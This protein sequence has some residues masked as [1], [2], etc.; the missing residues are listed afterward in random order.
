MLKRFLGD[1]SGNYAILLGIT[2]LPLLLA[3]GFGVDYVRYV[4]AKQHL[5]DLTDAASLAVAGSPERDDAKLRALA[6]K[7][8]GG[9]ASDSRIENVTVASLDI[10]NDQVD[11]AL[12][13]DIP[14]YFM[15]LANIHRLYV[16]TSALAMRAVTGSVEV[17]LVLDNTASMLNND[18][19]GT[20][21]T[22][23][24]ALVTE[25]FKS[26]DANV[27]IGLVPYAE[28][29]NIGMANRNA[30]YL[31]VPADYDNVVKGTCKTITEENG[32]CLA[33]SPTTTCTGYRDGVPYTYSCGGGCTKYEKI[34][35]TPYEVC[36]ADK[37]QT[38]KWYGCI[39]SRVDTGTRKLV[40]DD[41]S[42]SILYPGRMN[43]NKVQECV[44]EILPLTS[45]ESTVQSAIT[46]MIT[47]RSGYEPNTY[48]PAGMI[49][50]VN[51]LSPSAPMTEG[52]DYDE[53]NTN[54]R[55]VIVL[56][57]DGLN[58]RSVQKTGANAGFYNTANTPEQQAP[59]N[60]D[61]ETVCTYAKSK[62][63]EVFSIAFMVDDGA[64][65]TMLQNCATDANHYYDASD[66]SKLLAAF[67]G[68]AQSLSQVRLAR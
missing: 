43:A 4:S 24:A 21:K 17:A 45:S 41:Q 9:N 54:P 11:L 38:Y 52:A 40:L 62:K 56:M 31:S 27:R 7:M 10:D 37:V 68:I 67:S 46:G 14:T 49:W 23:A 59:V 25:L 58:S 15:G 57:T 50:G 18:K 35:V 64:G 2:T 8:V 51:V 65:K 30:A 20:L 1:R 39:G 61:T 22:A 47:G 44:T 3:I 32:Q 60:T 55:K 48:I 36:S 12:D 34:K 5:Q 28:Y 53:E 16:E 13:G 19:I 63:I 66:S 6:A 29:I 42:P 33:R 26:K